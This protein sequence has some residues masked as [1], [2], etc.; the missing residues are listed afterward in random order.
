MPVTY[1]VYGVWVF[2]GLFASG[3]MIAA[4]LL[5]YCR[6]GTLIFWRW[7]KLAS[8]IAGVVSVA[9]LLLSFEAQ[10]RQGLTGEASMDANLAYIHAKASILEDIAMNCGTRPEAKARFCSDLSNMHRLL[11]Y[12]YVRDGTQIPRLNLD[13][14][15][16][17][18][19]PIAK[20]VNDR[21]DY[22]NMYAKRPEEQ[23]NLIPRK[24]RPDI[25]LVAALLLV[26]ALS[27]SVGEAAFQLRVAVDERESKRR[28][29]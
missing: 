26:L 2:V 28:S 16:P 8:S 4:G 3:L 17:D 12:T 27:A 18:A 24:R 6:K 15:S 5:G 21:I 1:F 11:H 7:A 20:S 25:L 9:L 13:Q 23:W 19:A 14:Y 22:I 10:M 29:E